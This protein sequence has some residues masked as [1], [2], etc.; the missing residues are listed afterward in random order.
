MNELIQSNNSLLA[1]YISQ[2]RASLH[3]TQKDL[4][5]RLKKLGYPRDA[6]TIAHWEAKRYPVPLELIEPL[7]E[8]LEEE[9]PDLLYELAGVLDQLRGG[10]IVKLLRNAPQEEIDRAERIIRALLHDNN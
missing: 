6:T 2:R 3:L 10:T 7:S 5:E 8:A 9:A 4:A 1:E